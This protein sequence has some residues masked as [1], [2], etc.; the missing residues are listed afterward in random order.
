[1]VKEGR[2]ES[3]RPADGPVRYIILYMALTISS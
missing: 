1:M 3:P 2:T